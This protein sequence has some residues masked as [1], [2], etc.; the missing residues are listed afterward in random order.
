[1]GRQ[2]KDPTVLHSSI[3]LLQERFRELQRVKAMREERELLRVFADTEAE[4]VILDDARYKKP[5]WFIHPELMR[6]SRPLQAYPSTTQLKPHADSMDS[7]TF[8]TSLS[9]GLG[10]GQLIKHSSESFIDTEVD[11]TLHL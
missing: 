6:P 10:S 8:N 3:A 7:Q 5:A 11:T 2:T 1:M 9:I 4:A